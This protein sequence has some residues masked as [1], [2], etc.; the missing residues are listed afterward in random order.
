M[1]DERFAICIPQST[2]RGRAPRGLSTAVPSIIG[3]ASTWERLAS[4]PE[5]AIS[6]LEG[7]QPTLIQV[8]PVDQQRCAPSPPAVPAP[9]I[10]TSQDRTSALSDSLIR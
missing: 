4:R 5:Q 6:S 7:R 1:L 8:P 2:N 3:S 9:M 10:A